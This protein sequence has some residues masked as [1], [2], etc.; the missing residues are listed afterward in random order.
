M[1]KSSWR[2]SVIKKEKNWGEEVTWSH[3]GGFTGKV[4]Y[5]M[6]GE[7]TSFKYFII[8]DESF[9]ILKGRL[10]ITYGQQQSLKDPFQHPIKKEEF[11]PGDVLKVQSN[12][13]Y[14]LKALDDSVVIEISSR[15]D[16]QCVYIDT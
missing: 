7:S 16:S 14:R 1:S 9:M 10:M 5:I 12:C 6:K 11:I 4:L 8:K 13:P 2:S 15:S 3:P